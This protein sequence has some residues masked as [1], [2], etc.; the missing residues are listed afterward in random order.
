M[1]C[2][3]PCRAHIFS[4]A[5]LPDGACLLTFRF[6]F[7][8]IGCVCRCEVGWHRLKE[9]SLPLDELQAVLVDILLETHLSSKHTQPGTAIH[10]YSV[11][12]ASMFP[13]RLQ[14]QTA[15]SRDAVQEA[16]SWQKLLSWSHSTSPNSAGAC[17]LPMTRAVA[18][19]TDY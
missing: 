9:L 15:F 12:Q 14:Q 4:P 3:H 17:A 6:V 13:A 8:Q 19:L 10:T 5:P 1:Q 16:N 2:M 7:K 18:A 11:V